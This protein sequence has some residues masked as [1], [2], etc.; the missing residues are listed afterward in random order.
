MKNH[1]RMVNEAAGENVVGCVRKAYN[2]AEL[3]NGEL[4]INMYGEV[5]QTIPVDWWTGKPMDGLYICEKDFL[6]DL[7]RYK[8]MSKITVR[9]NS[10]GGDLYAGLAIANRMKD[11]DAEIVTIV[12]ALCASAAVAIQQ[13]GS[14]RKV[15]KGSQIMIHEPSCYIYGR[16]DVQG[17]RKVQ[18]QLEAGKK[19][20]IK[21]YEDRTGRSE[22]ELEKMVTEDS[23]LTGQEAIDEGFADELMEGEVSTGITEDKKTVIS[24]GI[25]F[26]ISA[27]FEIPKNLPTIKNEVVTG[28][29][30]PTTIKTENKGGN[31]RMTK[32][33]LMDSQ[34]DLYNEIIQEVQA[35]MEDRISAAVESERK[36]IQEIDEIANAVGDAEMVK[37][38]KFGENPMN[39]SQ[40]ALEALKKQNAIGAKFLSGMEADADN[41]GVEGVK[42]APNAGQKSKEEQEMQDVMDAAALIAGCVI[43]K[44]ETE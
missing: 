1:L 21:V 30:V 13:T 8:N 25:V 28:I 17:L 35:G 33:E 23:W 29:E 36:R 34:P 14:T 11:L 19:S 27:F 31:V 3:G 16:Y 9:I 32:K 7:D 10:V 24:N 4:E 42:P 44:G 38:A 39:A 43:K 41:S 2:I 18:K 15:Y 20:I 12:D 5:V 22:E 37:N 6:D 26:P 40:M